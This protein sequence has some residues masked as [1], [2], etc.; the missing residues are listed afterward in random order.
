MRLAILL[1]L[2]AFLVTLNIKIKKRQ[3]KNIGIKGEKIVEDKLNRL[4]KRQKGIILKNVVIPLKNKTTEIDL[5]IVLPK[6]IVVIENKHYAG[7]IIGKVNEVKWI[8][9]KGLLEKRE[10]YNP[11][12]QNN[13]HINAL[14]YN[15]EAKEYTDIP[16]LN[17]VTFSYPGCKL[18]VKNA[19][20]IKV[21]KVVSWMKRSTRNLP[22]SINVDDFISTINNISVEKHYF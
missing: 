6:A 22:K 21:N 5:L 3:I 15:L 4:I 10:F 18:K 1:F 19:N 2:F 13:L 20:V 8:Q 7:K 16:I 9:K 11:I 12:K 14:K 17:L